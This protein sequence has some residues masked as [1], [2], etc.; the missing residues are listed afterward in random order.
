MLTNSILRWQVNGV[1]VEELQE[2]FVDGV[3]ELPDFDY[4]L[5]IL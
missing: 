5:L 1:C 3:G 2:G 4:L